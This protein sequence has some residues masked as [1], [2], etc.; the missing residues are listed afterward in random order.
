[1]KELVP[2]VGRR[3]RQGVAAVVVAHVAALAAAVPLLLELLS[4]RYGHALRLEKKGFY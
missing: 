4:G 3:R 1:M 2:V